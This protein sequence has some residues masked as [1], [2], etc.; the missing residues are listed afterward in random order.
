LGLEVSLEVECADAK[1]LS[2]PNCRK[3]AGTNEAID[4]HGRYPHRSRDFTNRKQRVL[5]A[6][7]VVI[8]EEAEQSSRTTIDN[9]GT[10]LNPQM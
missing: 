9:N 1:M 7:G 6:H 3:V 8:L 2:D 10:K 4:R 5:F